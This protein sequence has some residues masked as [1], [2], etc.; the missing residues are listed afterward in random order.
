LVDD[1]LTTGATAQA[2]ARLLVDAGATRVDVYCLTRTPKP[3]DA[4]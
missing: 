1:V 4:A 2:L 3:G